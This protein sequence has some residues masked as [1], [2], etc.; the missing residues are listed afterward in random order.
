MIRF[1]EIINTTDK[2]P[3]MER[4]AIPAYRMGEVWINERF[5]VNVREHEGYNQLLKEGRLP[6][7]LDTK[8]TF[9][10]ITVNE[11]GYTSTHVVVGDVAAVAARLSKD[12]SML[13]K[14]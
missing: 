10:A 2:N 5:V 6:P 4:I 11:G 14:G 12:R 13:L 7:E 9:T 3:R 8:H 1:V